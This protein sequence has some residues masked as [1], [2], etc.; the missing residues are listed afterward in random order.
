MKTLRTVIF[1]YPQQV[2]L[3]L[4]HSSIFI[5]LRLMT[6]RLLE[7]SGLTSFYETHAPAN[8]K[9][10]TAG[11]FDKLINFL[12]TSSWA[13]LVASL[14]LIMIWRLLSKIVRS[15]L[16]FLFLGLAGWLIWLHQDLLSQ[17]IIG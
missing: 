8:L 6:S 10:W 9:L 16:L 17:L 7:T 14:I 4:L 12:E 13:W 11:S 5:W 3:F 2:I 1:T 15:L